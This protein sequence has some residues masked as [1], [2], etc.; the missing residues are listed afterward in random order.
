[1][2]TALKPQKRNT[3]LVPLSKEHH[4]G[5]LFCWKI[6]QG[7]AN[8]TPLKTIREYVLYFWQNNLQQHLDSEELLLEPILPES[9]PMLNQ[10]LQ[11]HALIRD[12]VLQIET[13]KD[14]LTVLLFESLHFLVNEHIRFEERQLFPHLEQ[15]ANQQQLNQIGQALQLEHEEP[16]DEFLPEFWKKE[17]RK[18]E[19]RKP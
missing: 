2:K 18:P 6:K 13:K 3:N 4:F 10:M 11:E 14:H 15:V 16:T 9:D 1:M 7:L 12:L 19:K 5:L 17:M 8:S